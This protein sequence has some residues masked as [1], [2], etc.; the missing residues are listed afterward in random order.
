[1][2]VDEDAV[3]AKYG[4]PPASIPD[5]LALVGDA[6]D[7]FPG[8]PGFGAKSAGAVIR[9]F[10]RI[11]DIPVEV[12][13]WDGV[14]VRGAAALA[15]TLAAQRDDAL[16]FKHLATLVV[17]KSLLGAAADLLWTGPTDAFPGVAEALGAP[18][19]APRAEKAA[20]AR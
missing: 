6:A 4:V 2:V 10:G 5:Y 13:A 15:S 19:L 1:V 12:A 11:E 17:R 7:G 9:R 8:I 3:L 20:A 14:G 18:A 16:L